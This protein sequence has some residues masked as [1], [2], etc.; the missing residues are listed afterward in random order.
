MDT[1]SIRLAAVLAFTAAAHLAAAAEPE[2]FNDDKLVASYR[3]LVASGGLDAAIRNPT[4]PSEPPEPAF[5]AALAWYAAGNPA[6]EG[7]LTLPQLDAFVEAQVHSYRKLL[8]A[9]VDRGDENDYPR[10]STWKVIQ[11]LTLLRNE[12]SG[13]AR[14]GVYSFPAMPRATPADDPW[15][16]EHTLRTPAEFADKVCK[17]S[18]PVLVKFGNTNCTQCML[19]EL[20][21]SVKAF[22][23]NPAHQDVD[24][25]K[26]WF[27]HRPDASFT[28]RIKDPA[29]LDDLAKAEG[30]RSSP[31]FVVYRNGRRYPCGGAFPDPLGQDA[32][33]DSCL[34]KATGEAPLASMCAAP[35]TSTPGAAAPAQGAA[36][37]GSA[38]AADGERKWKLSGDFRLRLEQ[39][40]DSQAADGAARQDRLRAR[41]RARL[42]F[43]YDATRTLSFGLRLRSGADASQQS[44]HITILDFDDNNTGD[45]HFNFEHAY[46]RARHRG[47]EAW[48]G[49]NA[50]P[51]WKPNELFWDDD[52]TP[53]GIGLTYGKAVGARGRVTLNG[54]YFA[55]PAGMKAFTGNLAM[56][57]VVFARQ[58]AGG[59]GLTFAGGGFGM[60]AN[61][62]DPSGDILRL[63]GGDRDYTIW[64]GNVQARVNLGGKP[65]AVGF[66]YMTNTEDY[67][68]SDADP[69]TRAH[70]DETDGYDAYV[71]WGGTAKK[72]DWLVGVWYSHIE[73]LAVN[74]SF[75][76]DDWVRWGSATQ[77]DASDLQGFELRGAV[78]LG[79]GQNIM[80]RLFLVEAISSIQDGKRFRLDYN[81]GF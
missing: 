73:A 8:E 21:G 56:G 39:D 11:K 38:P 5:L 7:S 14:G 68:A 45:A 2:R 61:P 23:E 48:A 74:A 18:R 78:G 32:H 51:A 22:A 55:L 16:R 24:V 77:T 40:W 30:V 31:T 57:Q 64:V 53:A 75:A 28:G 26:V 1:K 71:S 50:L 3:D 20:I 80:A 9:K 70:R 19:F 41:I 36:T 33:L 47:F 81:V 65:L 79:Q 25:Y 60:D 69:Y 35:G 72:N 27:G 17:G 34:K 58:T 37:Q 49:R 43:A 42:G 10:T 29:R 12:M 66:D 62:A 76:Q 52:V 6:S 15:E 59:L 54:G 44:P 67:S 63:G 4:L 13:A 46:L